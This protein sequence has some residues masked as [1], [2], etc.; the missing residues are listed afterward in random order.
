MTRCDAG[1][2]AFEVYHRDG[3]FGRDSDRALDG[4]IVRDASS[5]AKAPRVAARSRCSAKPTRCAATPS[6]ARVGK[7][8]APGAGAGTEDSASGAQSVEWDGGAPEC[9]VVSPTSE[10]N[11][12]ACVEKP[13]AFGAATD[14]VGGGYA[15]STGWDEYRALA[16]SLEA[17]MVGGAAPPMVAEWDIPSLSVPPRLWRDW[18]VRECRD[19]AAAL[20]T[21]DGLNV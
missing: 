11:A 1:G 13:L 3:W 18:W 6:R 5:R 21:E 12:L 17:A 16:D 19:G 7:R 14:V 4:C 8:A 9:H 10:G 15:A 20:Y 2:D